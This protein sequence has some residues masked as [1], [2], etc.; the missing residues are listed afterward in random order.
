MKTRLLI[1]L[2]FISGLF[3]VRADDNSDVLEK[4]RQIPQ[5][6]SAPIDD[7]KL[8]PML[9]LKAQGAFINDSKTPVPFDQV[10]KA[11]AALPRKSWPF[12]RVVL[13]FPAPFGISSPQDQPNPAEV[14]RVEADL[15]AAGIQLE[16]GTSN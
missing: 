6:T 11:L 1:L 13:Y 4:L 2:I 5:P 12:G 15:K 8:K 16:H 7:D 9:V 10:L 3:N 14:K